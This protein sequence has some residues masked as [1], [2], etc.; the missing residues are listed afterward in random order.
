MSLRG[1]FRADVGGSLPDDR[2]PAALVAPAGDEEA[3]AAHARSLLTDRVLRAVSVNRGLAHAAQFSWQRT[4]RETLAVDDRAL[5]A[6]ED[7]RQAAN[8]GPDRKKPISTPPAGAS[9]SFM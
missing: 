3:F 4:A 7:S 5:A 9:D 6:I 8:G 2:G 1:C